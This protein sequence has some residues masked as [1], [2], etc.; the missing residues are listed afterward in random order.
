MRMTKL[1]SALGQW[2][3]LVKAVPRWGVFWLW[4]FAVAWDPN[5]GPPNLPLIIFSTLL[6][7]L[8]GGKLLCNEKT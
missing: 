4:C 3:R 7:A 1:L 2:D 6:V 8:T 5:P